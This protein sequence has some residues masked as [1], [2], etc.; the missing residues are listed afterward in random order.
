MHERREHDFTGT[1]LRHVIVRGADV[2]GGGF[3]DC[4]LRGVE[5]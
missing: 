2:R 1:D 4:R 5:D 3:T